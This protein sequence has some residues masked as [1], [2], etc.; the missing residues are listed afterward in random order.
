[1]K[2]YMKL[3]SLFDYHKYWL[4]YRNRIRNDNFDANSER[5]LDFKNGDENAIEY[6]TNVITNV[7]DEQWNG[8]YCAVVPSHD[9]NTLETPM[10]QVV[11]ELCRRHRLGNDAHVLQRIKLIQKLSWG[12]N[13]SVG[14]HL[15][16][17]RIHPNSCVAGKKYLLFDDVKTTGNSLIACAHLLKN[18]GANEVTAIVLGTTVYEYEYANCG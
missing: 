9:P 10:H 16:S 18:A 5:I 8:S 14:V 17:I 3:Y 2:L 7:F 1:M 6:F 15:D 4:S 13:R 11:D 12:G